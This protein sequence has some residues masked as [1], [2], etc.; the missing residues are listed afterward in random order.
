MILQKNY[1]FL[2]GNNFFILLFFVKFPLII[3]NLTLIQIYFK[4]MGKSFQIIGDI[5]YT[6]YLLH[7]LIQIIF[8][9]VDK[10]FLKIN[11]DSNYVFLLFF[12]ILFFSSYF[13]YKYFEVKAKIILRKKFIEF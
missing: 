1:S 11:F 7:F 8:S 13:L 4:N 9:L 5:S 12:S 2:F 6:I 10:S 3:L